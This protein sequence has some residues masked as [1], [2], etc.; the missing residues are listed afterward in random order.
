MKKIIFIVA[1]LLLLSA[2][3]KNETQTTEVMLS[4]VI[5]HPIVV[6]EWK[7]LSDDELVGRQVKEPQYYVNRD[8]YWYVKPINDAPKNVVLLT[9]DDGPDKYMLKMA[10]L[11]KKL[12]VKAIFFVNGHFIDS[13]KEKEI[14]KEIYDLGFHIGN[15]TW[16]HVNLKKMS[17]ENQRETI[18]KLNDEIEAITGERPKFFR[19]PHGANTDL[20]IKLAEEEKMLLMNWSYGYDF[21]KKYM[22]ADALTDIMLNT[23]LLGNGANI[24]MHDR[25]WTLEALEN[26]VIGLQDKGF[27]IVD[28]ALIKTP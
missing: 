11:L 20:A 19:A 7:D 24:L 2:C 13:E 18:V 15:H 5:D 1:F 28:P 14:L 12:N 3:T 23:N 10:H 26:I 17:E 4:E 27:T 22:E 16:H 21:K 8:T 25:K 6:T 9:I